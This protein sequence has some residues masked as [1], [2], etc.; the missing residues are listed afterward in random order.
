MNRKDTF[1]ALQFEYHNILDD[2][3]KAITTIKRNSFV[4]DRNCNLSLESQ[5]AQVQL[6]TK[7][8]FVD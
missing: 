5:S 2:Q 3:I 7:T 4:N 6:M 8:L 1:N